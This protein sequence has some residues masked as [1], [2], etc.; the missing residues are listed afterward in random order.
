MI[1]YVVVGEAMAVLIVGIVI[2]DVTRYVCEF[3]C[4]C[5]R[6]V[7]TFVSGDLFVVG[8]TM[9]MITGLPLFCWRS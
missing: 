2:V 8:M 1:V 7:C 5:R 4:Y 9:S 3:G 6:I